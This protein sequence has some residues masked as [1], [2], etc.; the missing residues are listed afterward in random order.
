[1]RDDDPGIGH[2]HGLGVDPND[3]ALYLAGH[4][5]LFK[6]TSVQTAQRVAGRVQD[7]MGFTVIGPRTFLASGHPGEADALPHLGLIRTT[8][9]GAT[10]TTVSEQGTADFHAL[11]PAG[12]TLYA[13][14]S[15]TGRI[16]ASLDA[17]AT[18]RQGAQEQVIDLAAN[19][20]QPDRLYAATPSGLQVSENGGMEFEPMKAAPV[21]GQL[22]N[23]APDVLVGPDVDG[24]IHTSS[25]GG[26]TWRTGGSLPGPASAFTAID[27]Q[28]LLA[29]TENGTVYEST[30]G[31][32]DFTVAFRPASG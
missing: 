25:D 16:R 31:G 13:F 32:T 26:K 2:I 18:W 10:W 4:Y 14:D 15:Q 27:R 22:D 30:N 3:G 29:S 8:D 21:L 1:M 20:A 11:Q 6:V 24:R 9:A 19:T 5:G 17:G 28:R 12:D 7:H 23:P